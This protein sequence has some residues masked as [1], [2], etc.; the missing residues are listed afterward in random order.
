MRN[1]KST[2]AH[3][4][5]YEIQLDNQQSEQKF[6]TKNEKQPPRTEWKTELKLAIA[7]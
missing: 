4:E 6:L 7:A 1:K 5:M 2:A 3:P